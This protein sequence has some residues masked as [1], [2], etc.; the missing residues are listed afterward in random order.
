M[1]IPEGVVPTASGYADI[2]L[3]T[4]SD[5]ELL[6]RA[7]APVFGAADKGKIIW[8]LNELRTIQS[9]Q[10][11]FT[12]LISTPFTTTPTAS[13]FRIITPQTTKFSIT[14]TASSFL[15]TPDAVE[16]TFIANSVVAG[17]NLA[18]ALRPAGGATIAGTY[19]Y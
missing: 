12:I 15:C 7:S 18:I 8:C 17:T 10:D 1:T 2:T 4:V 19:E 9:V 14:C 16:G 6:I 3:S 5:N 11:A 13:A